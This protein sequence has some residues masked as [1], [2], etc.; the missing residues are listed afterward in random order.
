LGAASVLAARGENLAVAALTMA[1]FNIGAAL[2]LLALGAMS[3]EA[4]A[5]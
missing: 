1:A 3:R 2:P 5:R 4:M